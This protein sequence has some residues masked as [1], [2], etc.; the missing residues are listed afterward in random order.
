MLLEG[1]L[2]GHWHDMA[3]RTGCTV[4]IAPEGAQGAV[5]IRG[6][7][8]GTRETAS[9]DPLKSVNKT[10]GVLLTGGSAFGL[11][12]AGGVVKVLEERGWGL[13]VEGI[14][15]PIVPAAVIFDLGWGDT[16]IRPSFG[17]GEKAA[18]AASAERPAEGP[19]GVGCGATVGKVRGIAR[20]CTAGFAGSGITLPSGVSVQAFVVVNAFGDV[21]DPGTG[22]I[23]AGTLNDDGTFADSSKL[24]ITEPA[25]AE[26]I[27]L[28]TTLAVILTDASLD[29][30]DAAK[31]AAAASVGM[32]RSI[33]PCHSPYDGDAVF[34]MAS[35]RNRRESILT[36]GEAAATALSR[37]I[38]AAVKGSVPVSS[39]MNA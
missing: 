28:N 12:A 21:I 7:A 13:S 37:A 35:C 25:R 29:K 30:R 18:L 33:R 2:A 19:V 15:I 16:G 3:A 14:T 36:L 23:L 8:P 39:L 24:L 17:S 38:V 11:D 20:A 26:W 10:Y 22:E 5:D 34:V 6:Q 1:F 27:P 9:L 31:L 32:A 4:F